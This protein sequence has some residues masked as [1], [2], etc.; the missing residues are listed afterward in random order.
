MREAYTRQ[1]RRYAAR[2]LE[3]RQ[4]RTYAGKDGR[5]LSAPRDDRGVMSRRVRRSIA[6]AR[7]RRNWRETTQA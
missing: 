1:Q 5:I 2:Q 7:A 6:L 3:W 4:W